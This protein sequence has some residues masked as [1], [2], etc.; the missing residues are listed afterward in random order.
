MDLTSSRYR[1]QTQ[2]TF[3]VELEFYVHENVLGISQEDRDNVI[4]GMASNVVPNEWFSA[5]AYYVKGILDQLNLRHQVKVARHYQWEPKDPDNEDESHY[6]VWVITT[7]ATLQPADGNTRPWIGLEIT[8]PILDN[9]SN[10]LSCHEVRRVGKA[11]L[12]NEYVAFNQKCGFHVHVGNGDRGL[13]LEV[14]QRLFSLLFLYGEKILDGLFRSDR[15]NN[16]HCQSLGGYTAVLNFPHFGYAMTGAAPEDYYNAC[17]PDGAEEISRGM[18]Q[19]VG[20]IWATATLNEFCDMTAIGV[21]LAVSFIGLKTHDPPT[22]EEK[23]TVEFRKGEGDLAQEGNVDFLL[24]WPQVC[25]GLLAWAHSGNLREFKR[26][27][28]AARAAANAR[29]NPAAKLQHLLKVMRFDAT[30][31]RILCERAAYLAENPHPGPRGAVYVEPPTN[32]IPL[33]SERYQ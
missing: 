17:F 24:Y 5:A 19:S 10:G 26:V 20:A 9:M 7:D 23:P 33:A 8:S 27:M 14:C 12:D 25:L 1:L 31:V 30:V 4:A 11:L 3:G 21:K 22:G 13:E 2:L 15:D 29:I 16:I 32:L 28:W 18:R 6:R